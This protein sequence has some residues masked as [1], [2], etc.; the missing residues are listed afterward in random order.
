MDTVRG[1]LT[2]FLLV[3]GNVVLVTAWLSLVDDFFFRREWRN[4]N[5]RAVGEKKA[6]R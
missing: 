6:P 1:V 2:V 5:R 3:V 4:R